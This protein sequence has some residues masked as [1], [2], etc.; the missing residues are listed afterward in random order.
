MHVDMHSRALALGERTGT[1]L[2]EYAGLVH[3]MPDP[4]RL[5][6]ATSPR[7]K[8]RGVT[9]KWMPYGSIEAAWIDDPESVAEVLSQQGLDLVAVAS[10]VQNLKQWHKR[11]PWS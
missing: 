9:Y 11:W 4:W 3:F 1:W 2:V 5:N 7:D 10:S 8:P 6:T